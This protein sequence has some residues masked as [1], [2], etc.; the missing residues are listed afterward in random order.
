MSGT[1]EGAVPAIG[2]VDA[3]GRLI[4]WSRGAEEILG[5]TAD[6]IL[7]RPGTD[8]R[9]ERDRDGPVWS[10]RGGTGDENYR[11]GI[12][13]LRHRSGRQ[14]L[15]RAES[16]RIA[17]TDGTPAWV[18]VARP[19]DEGSTGLSLLE[20][21]LTR[22][23]VVMVVWDTDLVPIWR[24][25]RARNLE[26]GF[27]S[28]GIGRPLPDGGGA[29]APIPPELVRRVLADGEPVIDLECRWGPADRGEERI[30]SAFLFRVEGVDGRVFGV[31]LMATDIT[32][33]RARQ[34]LG[35]L[36]EASVRIGTTLDVQ[37]TAQEL[38]DLAVPGFADY[39]TVDLTEAA[40]PG[41]VPLERL[42]T[43]EA[44][45]PLLRRAGLAS[46]YQAVPESLRPNEQP[47]MYVPDS[48]P[49]GR[50]LASGRSH[51]EPVLDTSPGAWVVRD[52]E[53]AKVVSAAGMH[54]QIMVPLKARG[55][56]LGVA[57]FLRSDN[58]APFT[59]DDL[60]LVE[61]LAARAARS[62]DNARRYT[63]EHDAALALQHRL[64][65]QRLSG[66]DAVEVASRYLPSDTRGVGGDWYDT[67]VL[68]DSRVALIVGDV[69]GHGLGAAANMG[70]L[71]AFTEALTYQDLP[72]GALL[73]H[74]DEVV[75]RFAED[76]GEDVV[77]P[78]AATCLYALYDP[79]TRRCAIASAGHPP[80]ALVHPAGEVSF[81]G[82]PSG[83]PIGLGMG[84][85]ESIE[86]ELDEGTLL[87]LYT[88]GLI[89]HRESDLDAGMRRLGAA[90]TRTTG[91]LDRLCSDLIGTLVKGAPQDDVTLLIAR[92]RR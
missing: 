12:L 85:H 74:L 77:S 78:V 22:A 46:T 60:L 87:V 36:R 44:G 49:F 43:T 8:A 3:E 35:L 30:Y 47:A 64:L 73:A 54:S 83:T 27:P 29:D 56:I 63:L 62:L 1:A 24:N 11:A 48:S 91:P 7:G 10:W 76:E 6:E 16:A 69:T 57:A 90:L 75:S 34:R 28:F 32:H 50:V 52:P 19:A 18:V 92:T 89:E 37:R 61:E 9:M 79:A 67:I 15:A 41:S 26:E 81:P 5:Y 68:P 38:A 51:F 45:V 58:P 71:R 84:G 80:P 82:V 40:L 53:R 13:G 66:G 70:R 14:I 86:L 33:S 31:C 39:V 2:V 42:E 72:P 88:D 59:G 21:L 20:P 23:P 55:Q 17:T 65:P 4:G 25:E